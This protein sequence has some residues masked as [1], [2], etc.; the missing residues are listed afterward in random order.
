MENFLAGAQVHE[1]PVRLAPVSVDVF[2]RQLNAW[3]KDRIPCLFF[4]DFEMQRPVAV[5]IE[6]IDPTQIQYAFPNV[7]Q[8]QTQP[9][10]LR[11]FSFVK[12]PAFQH[13]QE[14]FHDVMQHLE[15]GDSYLVNLTA[16]SQVGWAGTLRDLFYASQ[17][18][19][20]LWFK[21]HFVC[22]SP[23]AFVQM[24]NGSI[25]SYPMKGTIDASLPGAAEKI[26]GD[27]KEKAE[28]VT[29]VDLIRND[30][31]RVASHVR[32]NRFR[33]LSKVSTSRRALLQVSSEIEGTLPNDFHTRLGDILME[34][35]PAGSISGAPKDRTLQIIRQTEQQPRGYYTGV[36]GYWDGEV[37]D[38][39]VMIRYVEQRGADFFYRSG[40]GI[41]TR[42][43]PEQE[44]DELLSKIYVARD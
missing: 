32:V 38:S 40:G 11:D 25:F 7:G 14:K 20:K 18:P 13:Y 22:F 41:T 33:Y 23:E 27:A 9:A 3:G 26:L 24:R 36:M 1:H 4:I 15:R 44:Y 5:P 21:D 8:V 2:R 43:T 42:S 28:H 39:A 34:L 16:I 17:A 10:P 35:L 19:Y 31:G 29:M 37:L 30:V 6:E 12:P